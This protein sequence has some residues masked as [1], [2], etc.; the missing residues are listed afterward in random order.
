M[1][2]S[3]QEHA[4]LLGVATVFVAVSLAVRSC[5]AGPM[6]LPRELENVG[7]D[8]HLDAQLPFGLTFRNQ[9]GNLVALRD[10][11]KPGRP[12]L[13]SLN[14]SNC[15][16]LCNEQLRNLFGTLKEVEWKAGSEFE[17]VSVSIDPR[18]SAHKALETRQ[19]YAELYGRGRNGLSFLVGEEKSIKAL[20]DAVGFRYQY[21]PE[22][23]E[24]AHAAVAYLCTPDGRISRYL[25]GV[26][27]DPHVLRLS[28]AEAS[29]GGIGSPGDQL[30][31]FCFHYDPETGRYAPKVARLVM[32][33][34]GC[35]TVMLLVGGFFV[36][37]TRE[38]SPTGAAGQIAGVPSDADPFRPPR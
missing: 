12:V 31:L 10:Y 15:P 25:Y 18:E 13:L 9:D 37:K 24:Y 21:L 2:V 7:V 19:K 36:L 28:L 5:P 11:F 29:Q 33:M 3:L 6:D 1:V 27:F 4:R 16:M 22:R 20:A 38:P 26:A 32:M 17:F 30:L 8:E 23:N 34:A 14:F 35:L